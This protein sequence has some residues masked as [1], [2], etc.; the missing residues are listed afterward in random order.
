MFSKVIINFNMFGAFMK[1]QIM[2]YLDNTHDI[3]MHRGWCKKRNTH[4]VK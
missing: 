3:S 4:R 2:I 1:D